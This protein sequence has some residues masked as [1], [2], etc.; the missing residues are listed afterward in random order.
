[1]KRTPKS[2]VPLQFPSS[3]PHVLLSVFSGR[4]GLIYFE[5]NLDLTPVYMMFIFHT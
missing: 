3:I 5:G 4:T 1:M 2:V